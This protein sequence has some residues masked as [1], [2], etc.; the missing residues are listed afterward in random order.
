MHIAPVAGTMSTAEPIETEGFRELRRVSE[1]AG[2]TEL[3]GPGARFADLALAI[4]RRIRERPV[5]SL[6]VAIGVG[7]VVGGALSIRAGRIALAAAVRHIGR[8]VLK[9]VL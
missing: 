8:E 7:F 4:A 9:Q 2:T 5:T 3:E 6:A 1:A